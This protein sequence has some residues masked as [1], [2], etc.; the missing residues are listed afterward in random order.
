[1]AGALSLRPSTFSQ[2]GLIDDVDVEISRA[3]FVSYDFEGKSDT[4]KLC[5]LGILKDNDGN[6]HPQYWSAGDL[7]YFVPSEDPKNA[8]LNGITCVA[9]GEKSAL[10]GSTNAALFLNSLVQI[11]F[12][13]DKLDEGDLRV[14][15]G[16]KVHVNR[17]AQPKRNNLP[18]KPGQSNRDPMVLIAT[19]LIALPGET[20]KAG[21]K[22]AAKPSTTAAA[23]PNGAAKPTA[24]TQAATGP[25]PALLE[26]LTGELIGL[27]AAKGVESLKK[28]ELTKGL[29]SSIDKSNANKNKLIGL[30]GRD[31]YLKAVEGFS[32]DGS[33]LTMGG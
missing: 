29:F 6:E 10:N 18:Q 26:E 33:T 20:P 30:A 4:P 28:V 13:E 12:P 3:R 27:F 9:V 24:T 15:E 14:L 7:Q 2:G 23:K 8:D 32:F 21:A 22:A 11:G 1:M 31:E 17:V 25:D 5:I 19:A 16:L